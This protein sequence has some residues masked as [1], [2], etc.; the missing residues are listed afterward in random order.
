MADETNNT[1]PQTFSLE[2]VRELRA[3]NKA[4]RLQ[5]NELSVK[6]KTLEDSEATHKK[7]A[8][9]AVAKAK[10]EFESEKAALKADAET[11]TLQYELRAAAK[12]AGMINVDDLK[13]ADLSGVK[14]DDKG[15]LQ[16][17]D[18]LFKSMRESKPYLFG[19]VKG[20]THP[21]KAPPTEGNQAPKLATEMTREEL[22]AAKAKNGW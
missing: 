13:L 10:S 21:G 8:D 4:L 5:N 6:V 16:G 1:Q 22:A 3:E 12:A 19:A 15:G 14:L 11:R 20:N 17:A 2:Y 18:A 7:A 9:E